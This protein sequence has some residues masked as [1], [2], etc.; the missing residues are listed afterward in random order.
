LV[1]SLLE[2]LSGKKFDL[3]Y[4]KKPKS[5][6]QYLIN[7]NAVFDYMEHAG[8]R[9]ISFSAETYVDGNTKLILALLWA[10]IRKFQIEAHGEL[11]DEAV[12]GNADGKAKNAT[13]GMKSALLKWVQ[14]V[15]KGYHGVDVKDFTGSFKDGLAFNALLHYTNKDLVDYESLDEE[16][17]LKNLTDCFDTAASE[18]GIP[19]LLAA[20]DVNQ[21]LIDELACM[22]YVSYF[23]NAA[24]LNAKN[25]GQTDKLQEEK[26]NLQSQLDKALS[27]VERLHQEIDKMALAQDDLSKK[28]EAEHG[29]YLAALESV[30]HVEDE[31]RALA[32]K[33]VEAA[34]A[35]A[36]AIEQKRRALAELEKEL[37]TVRQERDA[38][39]SRV[40]ELEEEK[41][42][43]KQELDAAREKIKALSD[44][45][46]AAQQLR[47]DN[48]KLAA[49]IQMMESEKA[50][51]KDL[52]AQSADNQGQALAAAAQIASE[53]DSLKAA[54]EA[55]LAEGKR[56]K[57]SGTDAASEIAA[58]KEKLAAAEKK[59]ADQQHRIDEL[60]AET[61]EYKSSLD[62]FKRKVE[63]KM[64]V[65]QVVGDRTK[66]TDAKNRL[67]L[68]EVK[69]TLKREE[70]RIPQ[71]EK[72]IAESKATIAE[73]QNLMETQ[74]KKKDK[75]VIE[76]LHEAEILLHQDTAELVLYRNLRAL[77]FAEKWTTENYIIRSDKREEF[78]LGEDI[79][80]RMDVVAN[81]FNQALI[82][83]EELR[84]CNR[85]LQVD[86]NSKSHQVDDVFALM[87]GDLLLKYNSRATGKPHKRFFFVHLFREPTIFWSDSDTISADP[88]ASSSSNFNIFKGDDFKQAIIHDVELGPSDEVLKTHTLTDEIKALSFSIVTS[89]RRLDLIAPTPEIY[90]LWTKGLGKVMEDYAK[91]FI[92]LGEGA[93]MRS[94]LLLQKSMG[95]QFN[96]EEQRKKYEAEQKKKEED[97]KRA[98]NDMKYKLDKKQ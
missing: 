52:M 29:N 31:K 62:D 30:K 69:E 14:E 12:A 95:A 93:R 68:H 34:D 73:C 15:T 6:I 77:L 61:D 27:E 88:T 72:S 51:L 71:L 91:G 78:D 11:F 60:Q 42:R 2:I 32:E 65:W 25:R 58:L 70:D 50:K 82:T 46:A 76:R 94:E 28:L 56:L 45:D 49:Q 26:G 22:T 21:G 59:N 57:E 24:A 9:L 19:K 3:R 41:N 53:R 23:R 48:G 55:L 81:Q 98:L 16:A 10:L 75:K 67:R 86:Y 36:E 66:E 64:L 97:T 63:R 90:Q 7:A 33:L 96:I 92:G 85:D 80:Q 20:D 84:S 89:D 87:K 79:E 44:A 38:L 1:V 37:A 13:L 74:G 35:H 8:I 43:L 5:R 83:I 39:R 17:T 18:L 47:E 54:N 4:E 40:D